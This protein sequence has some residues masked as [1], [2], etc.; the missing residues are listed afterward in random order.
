MSSSPLLPSLVE[1]IRHRSLHAR[2]YF[3]EL[4][5]TINK[6][7][8]KI[9]V[10]VTAV[11][12]SSGNQYEVCAYPQTVNETTVLANC[13]LNS[14]IPVTP[15]NYT[16]LVESWGVS[17]FVLISY[18]TVVDFDSDVLVGRV[19]SVYSEATP[20]PDISVDY[21]FGTLQNAFSLAV[22]AKYLNAERAYWESIQFPIIGSLC[23]DKS[24]PVDERFQDVPFIVVYPL[25]RPNHQ[26]T[27]IFPEDICL[28]LTNE[29]LQQY[30]N[31]LYHEVMVKPIL[32][33]MRH[34]TDFPSY[35]VF[36]VIQNLQTFPKTTSFQR[37]VPDWSTITLFTP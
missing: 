7:Q 8:L 29:E 2:N 10:T 3:E 22:R 11:I 21:T 19:I 13:K 34:R 37:N 6:P 9:L 33:D 14:G 27:S 25:Y 30:R 18:Y 23:P 5:A 17:F 26:A 35:H 1:F 20:D 12:Q 36:S 31:D 4:F 16:C 24:K 15:G 28:R 32:S